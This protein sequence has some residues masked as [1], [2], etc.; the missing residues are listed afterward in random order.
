[1]EAVFDHHGKFLA[2][3]DSRS[4]IEAA[5]LPLDYPVIIEAEVEID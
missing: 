4:A 5:N 3:A 1:M 2:D